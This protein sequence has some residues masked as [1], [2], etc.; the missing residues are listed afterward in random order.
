MKEILD[1][2]LNMS[3]D[4]CLKALAC[5]A[6]F[7]IGRFCIRKF[8]RSRFLKKL[9]EHAEP[10]AATF[11]RSLITT[12]LYLLLALSIIGILGIPLASVITVLASAGVAVSL[13]L[14]GALSNLAAG[15]MLMIFH[16]FQVGDYVETTNAS[17]I[18][19]ELNL[20]YTV[21]LTF[22][23]KRITVPNGTLMNA[24]ITDY[25]AE[26]LRRVD[27]EFTCAKSESPSRVVELLT[28]AVQKN[29]LLLQTPEPFIALSGTTDHSLIFVVRVWCENE[30]YWPIY[31]DLTQKVVEQFQAQGI[32]E[33]ELQI[34]QEKI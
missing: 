25:S 13:A 34:R 22:D 24:N 9:F 28:E 20:F 4:F 30:N 1:S 31:H 23:N 2:L 11:L 27:L 15:V 17:G 10:S 19:K 12:A 8:L 5:I 14:Q 33:P 6:V 18:V 26:K 7:L 32:K 16:P 3:V 29:K 21:F